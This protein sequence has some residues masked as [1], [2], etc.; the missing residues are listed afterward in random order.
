[1]LRLHARHNH[2]AGVGHPR[3]ARI[4]RA[5]DLDLA[6]LAAAGRQH[7]Q[8]RADVAEDELS[9]GRK[10]VAESIA[11]AHRNRRLAAAEIHRAAG[12]TAFMRFIEENRPAIRRQVGQNRPVEPRH[13][14]L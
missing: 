14:P 3:C 6:R 8:L 12:S 7:H 2:M 11:N 5:D 9:V 13:V 4:E 1:M 10:S